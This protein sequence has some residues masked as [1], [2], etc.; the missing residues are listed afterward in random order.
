MAHKAQFE[1]VE[2]VKTKFPDFFEN[3]VVYDFGSLD[4]NGNNKV[5]F[6]GAQ[7][8]GVDIG[9]GK[10]V[11]VV[12]KAH[13]FKPR[14]KADVVI[15]TEMLEHDMFWVESLRNMLRLLRSGGLMVI[16]CATTGRP[17]HGTSKTKNTDS[18]FTT[19][20]PEWANYYRNLDTNDFIYALNPEL[21][22]DEFEITL[23]LD[24][25]DIQFY[26]IKK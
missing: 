9:E 18:P 25:K 3:V 16:T 1:Y 15:S 20:V 13:E 19:Q 11:D 6:E 22:F 17:E 23:D 26:G 8:T 10:N 7:Y 21:N 2:S 14:K 5:H 12:S 24:H 4:I